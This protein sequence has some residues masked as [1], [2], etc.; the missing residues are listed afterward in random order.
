MAFPTSETRPDH[1]AVLLTV[2]SDRTLT[3]ALVA[4][5]TGLCDRVEDSG[6][7]PVVIGVG[8]PPPGGTPSWPGTAEIHLVGKWE[9]ALRRLE[10]LRAAVVAVASGHCTGPAAEV[11][12]ASD[13][14]IGTADLV[15]EVAG[16]PASPWPGMALHRLANQIGVTR[17]R[18]LVL[19]GGAVSPAQAL[20]IG[21][22]DEVVDTV[23]TA[24]AAAHRATRVTSGSEL[25][26]RRRLLLDA[27]T[28]SF[29]DALGAHLAACDRTLRRN[30]AAG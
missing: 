20:E 29:E 7:G 6:G 21:V 11:L 9:N 12:L 30:Q 17:A 15:L 22:L 24:V 19:F 28:T 8:G 25:A 23:D 5:L 27:T 2:G 4:E 10:R 14:R 26:L 13:Y 1:P 16:G 18:S 3:A